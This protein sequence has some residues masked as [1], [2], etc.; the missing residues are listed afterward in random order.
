MAL[1]CGAAL[2]LAACTSLP[3]NQ[4]A[5]FKTLAIANQTAFNGLSE[6]EASE[7]Q[8]DQL[9]MVAQRNKVLLQAPA[10]FADDASTDACVLVVANLG[11]TDPAKGLP[12]Q[13]HTKNVEKLVTGIADYAS[14][15]SDLAEAKDLGAASSAATRVTS[16]LKSLL[17]SI[18]PATAAVA[19]PALDGITFTNEQL[20]LERRR[21]LMLGLATRAQIVV[22][23]A[24]QALSQEAKQ[25]R[26]TLVDVRLKKYSALIQQIQSDN[27]EAEKGKQLSEAA[28]LQLLNAVI[29]AASAVSDAR[30]MRT[31]FA[32]LAKA[33]QGVADALRD[34]KADLS[35][36][37]TNA[38]TFLGIVKNLA[39]SAQATPVTQAKIKT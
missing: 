3:T 16:S 11:V 21:A 4:A 13:S 31:D 1:P 39:G 18:Y 38:Q 6:T 15:M 9:Q 2:S 20:R 24:A 32:S 12:L 36:T 30:A 28:R 7:V 27:Q 5:A 14:A 26:G 19:G 22:D 33:N 34:P 29:Q 17:N 10:C 35:V 8:T 23:G 37:S 25:L